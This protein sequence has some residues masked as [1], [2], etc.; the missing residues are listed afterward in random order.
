MCVLFCGHKSMST[1]LVCVSSE[2][3]RSPLLLSFQ[4]IY[5]EKPNTQGNNRG[6]LDALELHTR[7]VISEEISHL[8]SCRA[9]CLNLSHTDCGFHNSHGSFLDCRSHQTRS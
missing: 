7:P 6:G 3:G 4:L 9:A 5:S 8:L 1:K 2:A